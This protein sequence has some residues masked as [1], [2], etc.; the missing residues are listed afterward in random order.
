LL[1]A[2][3]AA[4]FAV[5]EHTRWCFYDR[6]IQQGDGEPPNYTCPFGADYNRDGRVT[7]AE[8]EKYRAE[9]YPPGVTD[10][11]HKESYFTVA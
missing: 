5:T 9:N 2:T 3:P 8:C 7:K 4:A 11:C 10:E 1:A 6:S